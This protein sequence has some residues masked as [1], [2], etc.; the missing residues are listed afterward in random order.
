MTPAGNEIGWHIS[1]N[2]RTE[3]FY[4]VAVALYSL[5]PQLLS[6]PNIIN[7]KNQ[8]SPTLLQMLA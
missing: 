3:M 6:R 2:N 5:W 4:S 7:T 1:L 8:T